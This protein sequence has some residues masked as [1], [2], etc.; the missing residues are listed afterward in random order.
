MIQPLDEKRARYLVIKLMFDEKF[1]EAEEL[2]SEFTASGLIDR[3][4]ADF[5][6]VI[7]DA[8]GVKRIKRPATESPDTAHA[9]A[10]MS[11]H[12]P[13]LNSAARIPEGFHQK[14]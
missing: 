9:V 13:S 12:K 6:Y 11:Y 5:Y 14:S 3:S 2:L 10:T 7:L 1:Q 4:Y 8:L